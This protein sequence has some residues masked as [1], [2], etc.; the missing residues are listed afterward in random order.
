MRKL[1]LTLTALGAVVAACS[2]AGGVDPDA[3]SGRELAA[4]RRALD[5][6]L[7]GDTLLSSDTTLYPTLAALVFP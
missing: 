1:L 4:V 3:I 6:A 5:S 2:D 7:A